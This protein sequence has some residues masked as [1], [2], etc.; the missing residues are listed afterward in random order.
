MYNS[1]RTIIK[2]K[3]NECANTPQKYTD[4]RFNQIRRKKYERKFRRKEI[5][6]K[7]RLGRM[8]ENIK[9]L[10]VSGVLVRSFKDTSR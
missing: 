6:D 9:F 4:M 1:V 2:K 10:A 5:L 7:K 8:R 3:K